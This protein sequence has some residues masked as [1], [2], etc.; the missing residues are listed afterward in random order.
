MLREESNVRPDFI[1]LEQILKDLFRMD[2]CKSLLAKL[3][4]GIPSTKETTEE[5]YHNLYQNVDQFLEL[6]RREVQESSH[7]NSAYLTPKSGES[8]SNTK[9]PIRDECKFHLNS[10]KLSCP[11]HDEEL[12]KYFCRQD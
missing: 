8:S 5:L 12:F 3:L 4:T 10:S 6:K 11:I 2:D 1:Q 7:S 9:S